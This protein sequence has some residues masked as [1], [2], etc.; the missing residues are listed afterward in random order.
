[1]KVFNDINNYFANSHEVANDYD[2]NFYIRRMH[3]DQ[4]FIEPDKKFSGPHKRDFFEIGVLQKTTK[5]IKIGNQTLQKGKNSLAIISP[6]Q[7]IDYSE[8]PPND[9]KGYIIYF[10]ASIFVNLNQT[11]GLQNEFPFFKIHTMP[12]YQLSENDFKEILYLSE[13]LYKESRCD[14]A[15]NLEIVRSLLLILLYKVKRST[16]ANKGIITMNR[17]EVIMSKFEQTILANDHK[18]LTVN[19]YASQ[20]NISPVYLTECVKEAT[21]KSAQKIIIDYKMLYAKT[22]L[23]QMN[24]SVAEIAYALDFNEVAN[25]NQFFKRNMGITATQ[26]RNSNN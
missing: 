14:K 15:H 20:M 16:E 1:M 3:K 24:K 13:E 19:E 21:G 7:V 6:F 26:F 9:D 2:N 25:F 5:N 23:Y 10:H 8:I 17:F 18:F 12:H 11:Y 22:L 4:K